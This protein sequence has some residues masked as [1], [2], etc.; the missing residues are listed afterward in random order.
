MWD[1]SRNICLFDVGMHM[2]LPVG[3]PLLTSIPSS[4][5]SVFLWKLHLMPWQTAC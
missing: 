3:S 2:Q 4:G 1:C 5:P